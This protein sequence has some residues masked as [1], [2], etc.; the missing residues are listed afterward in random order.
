[1]L[2]RHG[3]SNVTVDRVIGGPR[4]CSGLSALGRQQADRLRERWATNS[5]FEAD[6]LLA[7]QYP[8]AIETAEIV[9]PSLGNLTVVRDD[10]F[11]EHD[12]GPECDGLSYKEY[13]DRYDIGPEAWDSGDPFATTFPGGET[14]A[15]FQY[16]VGSAVRRTLDMYEGKTV[17]VACHGGVVDAILRLALKAPG[18]G[19]FQIHTLNTSITELMLV[20]PNV[21]RLIRYNDTAHL[22]GLPASTN[23]PYVDGA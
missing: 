7:S 1:M 17:V 8:R 4:T 9:A 5:E 21:W 20:K 12:P 16:R 23:P 22:A 3:E 2:V 14:V 10:G 19:A 11:G 6:V 13:M 18:M 15:A